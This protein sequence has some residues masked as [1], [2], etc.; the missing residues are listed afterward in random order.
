MRVREMSSNEVTPQRFP[1]FSSCSNVYV[2][3]R[4]RIELVRRYAHLVTDLQVT[5]A[6]LQTSC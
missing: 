5:L 3:E 4:Y 1:R 6:V 2:I